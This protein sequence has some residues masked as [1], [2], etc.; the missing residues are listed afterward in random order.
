[1]GEVGI[2]S[3]TLT[4]IQR[5]DQADRT[6]EGSLRNRST[7]DFPQLCEDVTH[8]RISA[9]LNV[10]NTKRNVLVDFSSL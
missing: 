8:P 9:A 3:G 4:C 6:R 10:I 1:M 2:P 5:E 7:A